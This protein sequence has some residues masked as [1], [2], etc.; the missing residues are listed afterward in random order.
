LRRTIAHAIDR[1]KIL[2]EVFRGDLKSDPMAPHRPL[3]GPYPPGSWAC[4]PNLAFDP[5]L[6]RVM[7]GKAKTASSR[8]LSLKYPDDDPLVKR[9]C[10]LIREQ[11]AA[12]RT[13]L[14]LELEPKSPR[15]LHDEVEFGHDY[16]LAYYHYDY[17]TDAYWL[18]PLFN[19]NA[20]A[21][22]RGGKNFLGYQNDGQLESLFIKSMGH[23][24][25]QEVQRLTQDIHAHLYQRMP[26]IPLWQLDTHLAIHDDLKPVRLDPLLVF[27][28]VE[29]WK[30]EKK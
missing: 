15:Q 30:L 23:C 18:W 12:L 29:Q 9:A 6:A 21:L 1:T 25:F 16:E 5:A 26:L 17:P 24:D 4:K 28:D 20:K 3:N 14:Q 19:P 11:V 10:E 13:G 2:N 22:D 7:A 8:R 27:T